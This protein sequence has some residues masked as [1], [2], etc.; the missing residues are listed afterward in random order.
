MSPEELVQ[1]KAGLNRFI[2]PR[3]GDTMVGPVPQRCVVSFVLGASQGGMLSKPQRR[4]VLAL[5]GK[6]ST[7]VLLLCREW[8]SSV[9]PHVLSKI[10]RVT[11]G[12]LRDSENGT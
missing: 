7:E 9:G 12:L 8:V 11:Y 4:A 1:L 5:L 6:R 10:D 3:A 2:R